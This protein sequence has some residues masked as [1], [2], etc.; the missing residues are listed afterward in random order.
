MSMARTVAPRREAVCQD[1]YGAMLNL[2]LVKESPW[3]GGIVEAGGG[4]DPELQVDALEVI[5][6]HVLNAVSHTGGR[7]PL[8]TTS[9]C[10]R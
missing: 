10:T 8:G 4:I 6:A 2:T 9:R 7:G 3:S 5:L 1:V